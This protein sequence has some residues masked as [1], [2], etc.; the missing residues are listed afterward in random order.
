MEDLLIQIYRADSC[1]DQNKNQKKNPQKNK[2]QTHLC[3]A[4]HIQTL[5]C[6]NFLEWPQVIKAAWCN[7]TNFIV[8]I[9]FICMCLLGISL[10]ITR[11]HVLTQRSLSLEALNSSVLFVKKGLFDFCILLFLKARY[12]TMG[13]F[14]LC[15]HWTISL[16][17]NGPWNYSSL[18]LSLK[19]NYCL[20]AQSCSLI[21]IH[22]MFSVA[23]AAAPLLSENLSRLW[24]KC[25]GQDNC[26]EVC[27]FISVA[28]SVHQWGFERRVIARKQ[29]FNRV[30]LFN[31]HSCENIFYLKFN[32]L[33]MHFFSFDISCISRCLCPWSWFEKWIHVPK[34]CKCLQFCLQEQLEG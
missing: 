31:Y 1:I 25:L 33:E 20:C 6:I 28:S 4:L 12:Q 30:L 29:T 23:C 14:L 32:L 26:I 34:A 13:M 15:A 5:C 11:E 18:A 19:C 9:A 24:V 27:S 17:R 7:C 16:L 22:A 10:K 2:S 3:S 21:I 8:R